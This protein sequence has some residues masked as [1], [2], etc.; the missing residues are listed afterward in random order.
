MAHSIEL[1]TPLVDS[2]LLESIAPL[3]KSFRPGEGKKMLSNS[4][5]IKIP[6]Q[7]V[8]KKK[9]GFGFPMDSWTNEAVSTL[10]LD[11]RNISSSSSWARNWSRALIDY[12]IEL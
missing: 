7:I 4:A 11:S 5:T 2:K 6:K 10:S 8:T 12:N 3:V 1:R 9:T